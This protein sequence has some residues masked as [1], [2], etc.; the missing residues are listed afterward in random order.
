MTYRRLTIGLTLLVSSVGCNRSAPET[1]LTQTERVPA[2]VVSV[3]TP[4]EPAAAIRIDNA[5][6][7]PEEFVAPFP[8]NVNFFSPPSASSAAAEVLP[9]VSTDELLADAPTRQIDDLALR[10]LG[11]VQVEGERPKVLLKLD[12]VLAMAAA[13][14]IV[15]EVEILDVNEPQIVVQF[16]EQQ[17][18]VALGN[19]SAST[20]QLA[21]RSQPTSRKHRAWTNSS[22]T[23]SD[24]ARTAD[25]E[26]SL[27]T[28]PSA[29]H[30]ELP[31][32]QL[33]NLSNLLGESPQD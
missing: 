18:V 5:D 13:G 3:P 1:T 14:D 16:A 8:E 30:V 10:I 32:V 7:K 2:P 25:D 12:G 6:D 11:F 31:Q 21:M 33:P 27:P 28:L 9:P 4:D 20:D 26:L 22:P 17:T 15:G 23:T 19:Q 24:T 29:P